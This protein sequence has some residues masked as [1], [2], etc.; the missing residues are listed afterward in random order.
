MTISINK[1]K[2]ILYGLVG[3]NSY[4]LYFVPFSSQKRPAVQK[5]LRGEVFEPDTIEF[6][7]EKCGEGDV[8]HAGTFFGDFLPGI[9][10][11]IGKDKKIWAFEPCLENFRCA[12]ITSQIN[13]LK[14]VELFNYG[15]GEA[16]TKSKMLI[17]TNSGIRLGG[18][19]R[20]LKEDNGK[21]KTIDVEIRRMDDLIPENRYVSI[22]QLDV[23]GYE[24]EA[25]AGGLDLINRC[26]PM[27]ILEDNKKM[28]YSDWFK[29]NINSIGYEVVQKIH[30]NTL[31][32]IKSLHN[33][34]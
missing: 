20:I 24:K 9:S 5:V 17:E 6:I 28:I 23:E 34:F 2:E 22:I 15:L 25:I 21:G 12:Q 18:A 16:N 10:A 1:S 26:K 3:S 31:L 29:L 14:N 7:R 8:I 11:S 30:D 27:L 33:V 32:A 19:S 4:G 13:N